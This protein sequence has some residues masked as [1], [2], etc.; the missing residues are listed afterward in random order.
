MTQDVEDN[1]SDTLAVIRAPNESPSRQIDSVAIVGTTDHLEY[2][3]YFDLD[4]AKNHK[5]NDKALG[6]LFV[7]VIGDQE[8]NDM[9]EKPTFSE[10]YKTFLTRQPND[11]G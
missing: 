10:T 5:K 11:D 2:K 6:S 4:V 7:M 8:Y 1:D 3:E 9:L